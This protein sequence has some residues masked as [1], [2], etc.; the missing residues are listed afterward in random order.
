M[1]AG[2]EY[3]ID[4]TGEI[5]V[6]TA[7]LNPQFRYSGVNRPGDPEKL[8]V[9]ITRLQSIGYKPQ[10]EFEEGL[11]TVVRWFRELTGET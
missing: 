7:G 4:D 2:H 9:D 11:A 3:T 5:T 8:V 10:F 6:Q 1:G